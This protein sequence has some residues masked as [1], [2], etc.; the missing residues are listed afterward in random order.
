M[1]LKSRSK[2]DAAFERARSYMI[3]APAFAG[4][5]GVG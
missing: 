1:A 2:H 3:W 5:T 4:V